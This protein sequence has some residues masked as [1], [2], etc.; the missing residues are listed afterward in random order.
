[1]TSSVAPVPKSPVP[2]A[3]AAPTLPKA[4][5][6]PTE[7]PVAVP[8]TSPSPPVATTSA[9]PPFAAPPAAD[10]AK[11]RGRPPK[12]PNA[13]PAAPREP[14]ASKEFRVPFSVALRVAQ[15]VKS[16]DVP[17]VMEMVEKLGALPKA[18]QGVVLDALNKL[19]GAE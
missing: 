7:Q 1:M 5:P 3:N 15:S 19:F 18:T 13:A 17:T 12:G 8:T 10:A 14:A 2:K 9:S 4:P 6:V 16:G 11:R